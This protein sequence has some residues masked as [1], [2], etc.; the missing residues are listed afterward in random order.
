MAIA[1]LTIDI[2]ARLADLQTNLDKAAQ[3]AEK[4]GKRMAEAFTKASAAIATLGAGIGIAAITAQFD[5]LVESAGKL[6]DLSDAGLGTVENLSKLE[7]QARISGQEFD[8]VAE[9]VGKLGVKLTEVDD[10]ASDAAKALKS[11]GLSAADLSGLD[12]AEQ[13]KKIADALANYADGG[14]KAAVVQALMGKSAKELLPYLKDL[15]NAGEINATITADQAAAADKFQKSLASLQLNLS[16]AAR[17][18]AAD[19]LPALSDYATK[20][21]EVLRSQTTFNEKMILLF[22]DTGATPREGIKGFNEQLDVLNEKLKAA[23]ATEAKF[24]GQGFGFKSSADIQKEIDSVQRLIKVL[25]DEELRQANKGIS[26][27]N[28]DGK[29]RRLAKGPAAPDFKPS[30]LGPD[31]AAAKALAAAKQRE[32][33]AARFISDL[34]KSNA[35]LLAQVNSTDELSASEKK[36]AEFHAALADGSLKLTAAEAKRAEALLVANGDLEKSIE[37]RKKETAAQQAGLDALI[38]EAEAR[39]KLRDES[40]SRVDKS[41]Y[42]IDSAGIKQMETD[43]ANLQQRLE[44]GKITNEEYAKSIQALSGQDGKNN[45]ISDWA[46]L[47]AESLESLG[48]ALLKSEGDASQFGDELISQLEDIIIKTLILK[49]LLQSLGELMGGS[50]KGSSTDGVFAQLGTAIIQQYGGGKAT[51]GAVNSDQFYRVNENGPE[52]LKTGGETFLM[53]AEGNVVPLRPASGGGG[54]AAPSNVRV[55]IQNNGTGQQVKSVQ[56]SFDSH[57]AVINIVL[58]DLK[59]GGR[60]SSALKARA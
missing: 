25:K 5:A 24:G 28:L 46:R 15:G 34:G 17:S 3:Q 13:F 8:A 57:G 7:Y 27:N 60:L 10:P 2:D 55:S 1:T 18:I 21:D 39:Q 11:I 12:T 6:D 54:A 38:A 36:L 58:D 47:G 33:A 4:N 29:D 50:A 59:T 44:E 23:Q 52:L 53:G 35:A 31:S 9:A 51:G 20:L 49:P 32:E 45:N 43:I 56:P 26:D 19:M 48:V 14:N 40:D 42:G 30:D 37:L 22:T 16:G 41:L